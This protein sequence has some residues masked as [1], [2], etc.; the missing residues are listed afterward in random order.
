MLLLFIK[1]G[2]FSNI[3]F[4]NHEKDFFIMS[5]LLITFSARFFAQTADYKMVFNLTSSDTTDYQVIRL[6]N[7]LSQ[8]NPTA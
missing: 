7:G 1:I 3:K 8:A 2:N 4:Q 6:L 5:E